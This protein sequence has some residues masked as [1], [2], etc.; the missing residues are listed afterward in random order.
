MKEKETRLFIRRETLDRINKIKTKEKK[1]RPYNV[2]SDI[3]VN[4]ALDAYLQK[5]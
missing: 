2:T 4:E 1:K 5:G 3:I